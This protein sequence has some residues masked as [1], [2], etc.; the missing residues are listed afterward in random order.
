LTRLARAE[1]I[2]LRTAERWV[3]RYRQHGLAEL[4]RRPRADRG[5]RREPRPGG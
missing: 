1:G 2:A 5:E 4:A 3:H